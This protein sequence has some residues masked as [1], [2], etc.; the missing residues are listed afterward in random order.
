ML[1]P[2]VLWAQRADKVM[3]TVDVQDAKDPQIEMESEKLS[4]K[5]ETATGRKKNHQNCT[6]GRNLGRFSR[7]FCRAAVP[8]R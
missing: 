5:A 6:L 8:W 1:T 7:S 2:K 3:L 4:F